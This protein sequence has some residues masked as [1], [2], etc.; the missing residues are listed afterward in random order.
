M[1]GK[2]WYVKM[3]G[4]R[5]SVTPRGQLQLKADFKMSK[6]FPCSCSKS[7]FVI[8]RPKN[9]SGAPPLPDDGFQ[10]KGDNPEGREV[11]SSTWRYKMERF[12]K[13]SFHKGLRSLPSSAA[14]KRCR[15]VWFLHVCWSC[16]G[17]TVLPFNAVKAGEAVTEICR[18][19]QNPLNI[20][21]RDELQTTTVKRAAPVSKTC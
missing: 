20:S 6:C 11:F 3:S 19:T 12:L 4:W 8:Q 17:A 9:R 18:K 7:D 15:C 1:S 14:V 21:S 13:K 5:Q 2:W 16:R 10:V